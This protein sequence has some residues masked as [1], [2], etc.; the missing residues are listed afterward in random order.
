MFCVCWP[1]AILQLERGMLCTRSGNNGRRINSVKEVGGGGGGG[2]GR[3]GR[4]DGG[5]EGGELFTSP[6]IH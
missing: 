1:V 2:G 3:G 5:G 6:Y 4:I